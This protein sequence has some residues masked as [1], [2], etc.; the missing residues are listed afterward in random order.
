[1]KVRKISF[2][3]MLLMFTLVVMQLNLVPVNVAASKKTEYTFS[4][5]NC[6][7]FKLNGNKLT[8]KLS[9]D[10]FY[11]NNKKTK[12]KTMTFTL[13][14][15]CK[16]TSST[17]NRWDGTSSEAKSNYKEIK[18]AIK[19]DRDIYKQNPD[20]GVGNV[21]MTTIVIKNGKVVKIDY[22]AA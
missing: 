20:G 16:W 2:V 6:S 17:F 19:C 8:I 15:N 18:K 3:A 13:A 11:K 22:L 14:K 5:G 10:K 7:S 21:G 4:P 1:M 9:G 12:K